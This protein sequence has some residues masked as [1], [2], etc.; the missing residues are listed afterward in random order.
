MG[1][2]RP[3]RLCLWVGSHFSQKTKLTDFP[4]RFGLL[5][6]IPPQPSD[7]LPGTTPPE[8]REEEYEEQELFVP[9]D[10]QV[11][12]SSYSV[13]Q[14]AEW[15]RQEQDEWNR[16]SL[17]RHRLY[18]QTGP[19]REEHP[20]AQAVNRDVSPS[21]SDSSH[22]HNH[23]GHDHQHDHHDHGHHHGSSS[24]ANTNAQE[25]PK[26]LASNPFASP[27][28]AASGHLMNGDLDS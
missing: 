8:L 10:V 18:D 26:S 19:Q 4:K 25:L 1:R 27:P 11:P 13:E 15:R 3:S 22:H 23:D 12:D 14:V 6:R 5:H 24:S 17:A 21:G 9:A 2:R 28:G 7:R 16:E 20:S